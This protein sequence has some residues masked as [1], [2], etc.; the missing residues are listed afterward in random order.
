MIAVS[1][2]VAGGTFGA[3]VGRWQTTFFCQSVDASET[4]SD[5]V[6]RLRSGKSSI[7]QQ[8]PRAKL[9]KALRYETYNKNIRCT[10]VAPGAVGEGTEFS[11][12]RGQHLNILGLTLTDHMQ[13][14]Q[15]Q[16]PDESI[17]ISKVRCVKMLLNDFMPNFAKSTTP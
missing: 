8:F 13:Q 7:T 1:L 6:G 16:P 11:E 9:E 10:V 17:M 15:H 14:A 3:G 2:N 4:K 5:H 12:V